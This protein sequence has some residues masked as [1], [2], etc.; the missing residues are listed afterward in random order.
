MPIRKPTLRITRD[1]L[2][3]FVGSREAG[4]Y[5]L[6]LFLS[7]TSRAPCCSPLPRT[8][9]AFRSAA[10]SPRW[11]LPARLSFPPRSTIRP[12]QVA[13]RWQASLCGRVRRHSELALLS[14]TAV[15]S[16]HRSQAPRSHPGLRAL[17]LMPNP[18]DRFKATRH[19]V[20]QQFSRDSRR[21]I[22][23]TKHLSLP[24]VQLTHRLFSEIFS[25]CCSYWW[26]IKSEDCNHCYAKPY[27]SGHISTT[28]DSTFLPITAKFISHCRTISISDRHGFTASK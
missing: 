2:I 24:D 14:L 26:D 28:G 25:G 7:I 15:D 12:R 18:L 6:R 11:I 8:R 16:P 19:A 21:K 10:W 5:E 22:N 4:C 3:S 1:M 23:T 17:H 9:K 13:R 20:Q 27:Y